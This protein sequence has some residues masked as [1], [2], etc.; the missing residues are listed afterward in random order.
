M[1]SLHSNKTLRQ[2]VS[3]IQMKWVNEWSLVKK[4]CEPQLVT[5]HNQ[6]PISKHK[7]ILCSARTINKQGGWIWIGQKQQQIA[8]QVLNLRGEKGEV[9]VRV[10]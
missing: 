6:P 3:G 2:P 7:E 5:D 9:C 10:R 8:L 4:H 1:V